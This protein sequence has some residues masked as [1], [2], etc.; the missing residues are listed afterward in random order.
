VNSKEPPRTEFLGL[1][2][3]GEV[4]T[5]DVDVTGASD[6]MPCFFRD[7][8]RRDAPGGRQHNQYTGVLM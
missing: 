8:P 7:L 5:N 1:E 6:D 2:G 3:V 4:S